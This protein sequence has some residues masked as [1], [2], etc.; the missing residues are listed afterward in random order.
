MIKN[1]SI[2]IAR[3]KENI[4]WI[5]QNNLDNLFSVYVYNKFFNE[6]IQLDNIGRESHTFLYH[7]VHNYDNLSDYTIFCQGK[8]FDHCRDFVKKILN[9]VNY[10]NSIFFLCNR[11]VCEGLRGNNGWQHPNGLPVGE[12]KKLLFPLDDSQKV[13]FSPGAQYI[14]PKAKIIKHPKEFYIN[15]LES[16]SYSHNPLEAYVLERLWSTIYA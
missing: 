6:P 16:V 2:V 1:K 11:P 14:V 8:P 10:S 9:P 3:Y 13:T 7:I 12:W 4:N 5:Y 15:L